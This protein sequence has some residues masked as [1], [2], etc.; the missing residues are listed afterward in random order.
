MLADMCR[1]AGAFVVVPPVPPP[2]MKD[3]LQ[4]AISYAEQ[5][6]G[7]G[8]LLDCF[9]VAPADMPWLEPATIDRLLAAFAEFRAEIIVP[10]HAGRRGHPIVVPWSLAAEVLKLVEDESLKTIV[11]RHPVRTVECDA[12]VLGDLDTPDEY[13]AALHRWQK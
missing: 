7:R 10:T 8:S 6:S 13:Q 2:E 12:S 3:S 4:A 11:E 9:L 1:T 5:Q